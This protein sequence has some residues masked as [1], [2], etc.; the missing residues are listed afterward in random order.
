MLLEIALQVGKN[1]IILC[2]VCTEE[3]TYLLKGLGN[4]DV[5]SVK[6]LICNN[7]F[8]SSFVSVIHLR[9]LK[10]VTG[11]SRNELLLHLLG[12]SNVRRQIQ[13]ASLP[14]DTFPELH[15][16]NAEDEEHKEAEEQNITQHW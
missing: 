7:S 5:H 11:N 15:A 13:R 12:C 3:N 10:E 14:Q 9:A 1:Q 16:D 2:S 8:S 4:G 6:P